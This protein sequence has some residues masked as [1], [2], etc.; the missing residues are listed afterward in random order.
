MFKRFLVLALA[1]CLVSTT[2]AA[3]CGIGA[4]ANAGDYTI[5]IISDSGMERDGLLTAD[6]ET[7]AEGGKYVDESLVYFL[8]NAGFNIDTS[9]MGGNYRRSGHN[10]DYPTDE[11]WEGND[12]RLAAIQAADLV[13]VSK[14]ANSGSYARNEAAGIGN[15]TTTAW[16][17]LG[18]PLLS[19]NAHL[20]RGQGAAAGGGSTKWGWT[21]GSNGRDHQ[22]CLATNMGVVPK[23]HPAYDWLVPDQLFDYSGNE[24]NGAKDT[25]GDHDGREPDLPV[26]D[27][28]PGTTILGYLE[29]D[30]EVWGAS[31]AAS[32]DIENVYG[33]DEYQDHAILAHLVAGIDLDAFNSNGGAPGSEVYGVLGAQRAYFGIWSYDGSPDYYWGQDLTSCYKEIFLSLVCSMVP[34][35]ATIALLGLGGL[36]LLRKRR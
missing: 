6:D 36:A 26:G 31:E 18:V 27:W 2:Y 5:M 10:S 14:F 15:S 8:E 3:E 22:G 25:D 32:K 9:G 13:I 12:G 23:N 28:A 30:P 17:G 35:P 24:G 7:K 1:L 33:T 4:C 19:Q 16:N 34:E 20:V 11:W 21:N 29:N